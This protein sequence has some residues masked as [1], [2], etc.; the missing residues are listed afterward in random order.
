M[1]YNEKKKKLSFRILASIFLFATIGM[2]FVPSVYISTTYSTSTGTKTTSESYSA[3]DIIGGAFAP[4]K[5]DA[6]KA[7]INKNGTEGQKV[8]YFMKTEGQAH[9]ISDRETTTSFAF[10]MMMTVIFAAMGA[11]VNLLSLIKKVP[12]LTKICDSCLSFFVIGSAVCAVVAIA[13]SYFWVNGSYSSGIGS[14]LARTSVQSFGYIGLI[15]N[16]V[17]PIIAFVFYHDRK[18]KPEDQQAQQPEKQGN[19]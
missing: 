4:D 9:N 16:L 12:T 1:A 17:I 8:A 11:I 2:L 13:M 14:D 15:A 7:E 18:L 19:N 6:D 10:F 5:T 3:A